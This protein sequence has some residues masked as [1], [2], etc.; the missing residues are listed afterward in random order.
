M[1]TL[2]RAHTSCILRQNIL[3]VAG[4]W[5]DNKFFNG[6]EEISLSKIVPDF[7]SQNLLDDKEESDDKLNIKISTDAIADSI[8]HKELETPYTLAIISSWGIKCNPYSHMYRW[9]CSCSFRC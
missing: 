4:G 6:A 1:S 7:K 8:A 5:D 3:I 2:Q 9:C